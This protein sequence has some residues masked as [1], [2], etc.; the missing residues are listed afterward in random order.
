MCCSVPPI[1]GGTGPCSQRA[2]AA[3]VKVCMFGPCGAA[4]ASDDPPGGGPPSPL[5]LPDLGHV[6]VEPLQ[7]LQRLDVLRVERHV[8]HHQPANHSRSVTLLSDR[9]VLRVRLC[10]RLPVL[11]SAVVDD[12]ESSQL[13]LQV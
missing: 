7:G 5:R 13:P 12:A 6:E 9:R 11:R 3:L 10:A 2:A 4:P 8:H 1:K